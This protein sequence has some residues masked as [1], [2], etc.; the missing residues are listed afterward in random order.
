VPLKYC[1][2]KG[3]KQ[4]TCKADF[5]KKVLRTKAGNVR[6]EKYRPR[7]VCQGVAAEMGLKT[8]GR[9]NALGS[10][11]GRRRCSWFSGTSALLAIVARS[12]SNV[13]CNYRVPLSETTHDKDCV[14]TQC[15]EGFSGRSL[16]VIAQRAMKQMTG[17][18][19]GYI[20]KRQKM[21][22]FE[23]KKIHR[24]SAP[25]EG[26]AAAETVEDSQF[27]ACPRHKQNV[28]DT[29]GQRDSPSMYRRVYA[30]VSVQAT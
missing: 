27:P 12:N 25:D 7:V 24:R 2:R 1:F 3:K 23:M 18:F 5:P 17:Y 30:V 29:G 26:E 28:F 16:C 9:R 21:G 14:L 15:T 20:S 13:Q 10:I 19:G 4:C 11:L 8:S 22:K 6:P